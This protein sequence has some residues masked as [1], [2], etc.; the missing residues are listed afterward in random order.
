M[1]AGFALL[2]VLLSSLAGCSR[3]GGAARSR[4]DPELLDEQRAYREVERL[5]RVQSRDAGTP[6]A[7]EA[8][9]QI[10]KRLSEIGVEVE[11]DSFPDATPQG[12]CVFHNVVATI[13]GKGE[14]LVVIGSHFDT[15]AGMPPGFQGANDSGSSTGLLIE[16][17]R[18]LKQSAPLEFA[19]QLVFFDGEE[20]LERYA[21]NDGLHGSRHHLDRLLAEDSAD[22][23]KA[24]IVLDMIGD[25]DLDVSFP[26]NTSP[27]L[28]SLAFEIARGQGVRRHFGIAEG[29]VIDDHLPFH[30]AGMRTINFIDFKFGSRPGLN[31][32]WHTGEDTIEKI[33]PQSLGIVG[34]VVLEVLNR[35]D[36]IDT[37]GA[38]VSQ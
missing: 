38:A 31:D 15:K 29:T 13:P 8:A 22:K 36:P 1:M 3:D 5:L 23:V 16:I 2:L 30:Q 12:E 18:V 9:K 32:Y 25:R 19:T 4:I 34:R 7:E 11:I 33:S 37:A 27:A 17:G 14:G 20:C 10:A 6:G 26:R 24:V 35:L 21:M 28:Q